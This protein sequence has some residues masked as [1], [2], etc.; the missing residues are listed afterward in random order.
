[1]YSSTQQLVLRTFLLPQVFF[2]DREYPCML[3]LECSWSLTF[4]MMVEHLFESEPDPA[5]AEGGGRYIDITKCEVPC[6]RR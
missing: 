4:I 3:R 1:M 5:R 2:N 6:R